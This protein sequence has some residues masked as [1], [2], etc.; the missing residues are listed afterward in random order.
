MEYSFYSVDFCTWI[1]L[2]CRSSKE[3]ATTESKATDVAVKE[4]RFETNSC[5]MNYIVAIRAMN[6]GDSVLFS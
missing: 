1:P 6:L 3:L 5:L 2:Y 4:T